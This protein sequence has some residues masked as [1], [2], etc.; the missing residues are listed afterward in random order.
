VPKR[1]EIV[2]EMPKTAL[3]PAPGCEARIQSAALSK[4]GRGGNILAGIR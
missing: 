4:A 1:G 3:S 2:N